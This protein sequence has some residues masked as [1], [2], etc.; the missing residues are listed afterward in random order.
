MFCQSITNSSLISTREA[1]VWSEG[2]TC[3]G[4]QRSDG[5]GIRTTFQFERVAH[6]SNSVGW[7]AWISSRPDPSRDSQPAF[8]KPGCS[9]IS[10]SRIGGSLLISTARQFT[11]RLVYSLD[12]EVDCWDCC[13]PGSSSQSGSNCQCLSAGPLPSGGSNHP[14]NWRYSFRYSSYHPWVLVLFG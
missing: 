2:L 12:Q 5:L 10:T 7:V 1:F 4:L 11:E 9:R 14:Y 8:G 13:E 6:H 3:S